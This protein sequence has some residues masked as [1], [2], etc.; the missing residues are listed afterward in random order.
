MIFSSEP[1]WFSQG[2]NRKRFSA[3]VP[4]EDFLLGL[5]AASTFVDA[6]DKSGTY[7]CV[8]VSES[9][10]QLL[11]AAANP[12]GFMVRVCEQLQEPN[13][14]NGC[15]DLSLLTVKKI[16]TI[17]TS[18]TSSREALLLVKASG[19]YI[20]VTDGEILFDVGEHK[21]HRDFADDA[22]DV[23]RGM[24]RVV[25]AR[26]CDDP[27]KVS[28][29]ALQSLAKLQRVLK[30][31]MTALRQPSRVLWSLGDST[32]AVTTAPK[33]EELEETAVQEGTEG[34]DAQAEEYIR[35][36][37]P[38]GSDSI[39]V[40]VRT[41]RDVVREFDRNIDAAAW[42]IVSARPLQELS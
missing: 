3:L 38:M 13:P 29:A 42:R 1:A 7:T 17:C 33:Q 32:L 26:A 28:P 14:D 19:D 37:E 20:S 5:R 34:D 15:V 18:V 25:Q 39:D 4:A 11:I 31:E 30:T 40:S 23:A 8:R 10:G 41:A 2:D 36:S 24:Y 27:V 6:K 21:W 35:R 16:I 22:P 12:S 9:G